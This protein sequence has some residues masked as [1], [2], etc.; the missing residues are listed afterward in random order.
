MEERQNWEQLSLFESTDYVR[1]WYKR[2]HKY[3]LNLQRSR[4]IT[5]NFTQAKEYFA[6]SKNSATTVKPL[7]LYYG[8]LSLSRGLILLLDKNKSESSMAQSHGLEVVKWRETLS[9]PKNSVLDLKI[10]TTKG[11]FRELV[12][13]TTNMEFVSVVNMPDRNA[14]MYHYEFKRPLFAGDDNVQ[15]S[16]DDLLSRSSRLLGMYSECTGRNERAHLGQILSFQTHAEVCI[17]QS[18]DMCKDL[19]IAGKRLPEMES[20]FNSID[21]RFPIP[22]L[23]FTVKGND[24]NDIKQHL[25]II[26]HQ[27]GPMQYIIEDFPNGDIMSTLL[28]MFLL[29]YYMGMLVRYFP[30]HWIA[31]I[32]NQVGDTIQPLLLASVTDI[33]VNFPKLVHGRLG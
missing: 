25:P 16:L 11:T 31:L 10:R 29:S 30:S 5:S 19:L 24:F 23:N 3:E 18:Q 15:I 27:S 8:V 17:I 32:Q 9:K 26:S 1:K 12:S 28:R 2:R 6:S 22:T 20:K 7:L 14:G 21:S 13:A 33:Q 4:E